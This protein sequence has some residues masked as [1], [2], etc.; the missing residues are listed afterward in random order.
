MITRHCNLCSSD[1]PNGDFYRGL[2]YCKACHKEK[3]EAYYQKNKEK[4]IKYA[5][6]YRKN[7]INKVR[8]KVNEYYKGRRQTDIEFRLR[9]CLRAR[10][11]SGLNRHLSGGEFGTSLELLG[12]DIVTWKQHLEKQFTSEMNWNNYGVYWEIDHIFPISKGGSFHYINT[13][14]LTVLENQTKSNKIWQN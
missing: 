12:C 4:K 5:I 1:K 6:E 3:R 9:E 14:P 2:T 7:N 13:Q 10:I 11:N 8:N